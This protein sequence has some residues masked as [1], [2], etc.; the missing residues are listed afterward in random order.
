[1]GQQK[2][3]RQREDLHFMQILFKHV[4]VYFGLGTPGSVM[5]T[6]YPTV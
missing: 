3:Q 2:Q 4:A 6:I 1:M 5:G